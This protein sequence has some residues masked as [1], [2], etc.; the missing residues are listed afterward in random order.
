MGLAEIISEP[1]T[2]DGYAKHDL[3]DENLHRKVARAV[4]GL[5]F[6]GLHMQKV[7]RAGITTAISQPLI[8]EDY[9]LAGVSVAF[10]T[11]VKDTGKVDTKNTNG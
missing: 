7:F 10:H 11:G 3:F 6:N 9:T 8:D 4:D 2:L 1:S 5:K